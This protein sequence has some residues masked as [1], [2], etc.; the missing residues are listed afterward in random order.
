MTTLDLCACKRGFFTLR[1]CG[2]PATTSCQLC[3]RRVCDEHLAP[4]VD[5]GCVCKEARF[6]LD[7]F[8][9]LYVPDVLNFCVRV[10]D[11]AGNVI[12][13]LGHYGNSDSA[14]AGSAIP[15]PAIPLG[16]PMTVGVNRA[17]RLYVGDVLNQRI[18]RVDLAYAA[19]AA[20]TA[21]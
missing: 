15:D 2:K 6:D 13:T 21:P 14:G 10:Y 1:D 12:A 16:W 4:R 20:V 8:G 17:G 5:G 9:R 19:E 3:T 11:N 18:V 7:G